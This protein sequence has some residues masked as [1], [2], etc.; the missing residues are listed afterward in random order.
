[1]SEWTNIG[2]ISP[3]PAGI[4]SSSKD[5]KRLDVVAV[6]NDSTKTYIA[7]KDVQAGIELDNREY[8]QVIVD[9]SE[10]VEAAQI[11]AQVAQNAAN[12][13]NSAADI[14]NAA[15]SAANNV[16]AEKL[17]FITPQM[18]YSGNWAEAFRSVF[19]HAMQTGKP[20]R[21]PAGEYDITDIVE[22][23]GTG[24]EKIVITLDPGAHLNST[25]GRMFK[26]YNCS[27]SV[28][29]GKI[30]CGED[31]PDRPGTD[32]D[33]ARRNLIY[34]TSSHN[35]GIIELYGCHDCVFEGIDVPYSSAPSVVQIY[36]DSRGKGG[37]RPV[38]INRVN[39][40]PE[41][42]TDIR[43]NNC[44]FNN[45]L[46]SA[47]HVLYHNKNIVVDGC[48]FTNALRGRDNR[49]EKGKEKIPYCYGVYTG[50]KSVNTDKELYF[51]PTD[52]YVVR[53]CYVKYCEGTGIDTHAASNVLYENNVL[54]DCDN[55][56]TAYHDYRRVR[57]ADGWV[58]ENIIVRNNKCR[59]THQFDYLSNGYPHYPFMLYN[60][61]PEGTMRNLIVENNV[62]D[63]NWYYLKK[64]LSLP[65]A[66]MYITS[67]DNVIIRNNAIKNNIVQ[68]EAEKKP[69]IGVYLARCNNAMIDNLTLE[70]SYIYGVEFLSSVCSVGSFKCRNAEFVDA[71]N[72]Y[73]KPN[74]SVNPY[75]SGESDESVD[76]NALV[77]PGDTPALLYIYHIQNEDE[78]YSPCCCVI[79]TDALNVDD[80]NVTEMVGCEFMLNSYGKPL[81]STDSIF[82]L[83]GNIIATQKG[84][85]GKN[86]A[87]YFQS[88]NEIEENRLYVS[89]CRIPVGARIIIKNK[90]YYVV[91]IGSYIGTVTGSDGNPRDEKLYF[92]DLDTEVDTTGWNA[93]DWKNKYLNMS[94]PYS[95]RYVGKNFDTFET[96]Y[97]EILDSTDFND[98]T[99]P[100][101]YRTNNRKFDNAPFADAT[102]SRIEVS[103][104][105]TSSTYIQ[106]L[107]VPTETNNLRGVYIR[108]KLANSWSPWYKMNMTQV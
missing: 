80:R 43:F 70:G 75:E 55:F 78:S 18:F 5:Y 76:S 16:A 101:V 26:V 59:T 87:F 98:Y 81:Y 38:K 72:L 22:I 11:N 66:V 39:V 14:A 52:G 13:A 9:V 99:R 83:D 41:A 23:I 49:L 103:H 93:D 8:W 4:W 31:F 84:C 3:V 2:R 10:A 7:I 6:S 100:G 104:S 21:I 35:E 40:V 74:D 62:I 67:T 69:A 64:G 54:E 44:R 107:Y 63:T 92:Y 30:T 95:S 53:N 25:F 77:K 34:Q 94:I 56:I 20:V 48:T 1:M 32:R 61:G 28:Y 51:T 88:A 36:G 46:L 73:I 106:K 102:Y 89:S 97:G 86:K 96:S 68:T 37:D 71:H 19:N 29:G 58:M 82:P 24:N 42:C 90:A 65:Y 57:T 91:D 79:D 27:F 108:Y 85:Y 105:V 60:Y 33:D 50:V 12:S 15:A 47:I 17:G 45:F